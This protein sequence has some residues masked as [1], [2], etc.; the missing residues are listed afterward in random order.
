MKG[1]KG[2][3]MDDWWTDNGTHYVGLFALY[4]RSLRILRKGEE[5][6]KTEPVAPL[7]AASPMAQKSED[8]E[9]QSSVLD[10]TQEAT[11][12]PPMCTYDF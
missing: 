5:V 6:W 10:S 2:A 3:L 12:F 9:D 4:T 8:D 11:R 7:I 1:G